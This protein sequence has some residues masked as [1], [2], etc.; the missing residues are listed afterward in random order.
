MVVKNR[1][2]DNK[3]ISKAFIQ[4]EQFA[5][6]SVKRCSEKCHKWM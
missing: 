5:A 4:T 6:H 1:R 2:V 3:K